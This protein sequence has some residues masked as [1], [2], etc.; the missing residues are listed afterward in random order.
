MLIARMIAKGAAALALAFLLVVG[1]AQAKDMTAAWAGVYG[2]EDG[3]TA[4]PF[5]LTLSQ[6]GTVITG[7]IQEVQTF[8]SKSSDDKLRASIIGSVSGHVVKFT[9]TYDGTGGQSH[10]VNYNGT[11]VVDGENMFMFGTW[12]IGADVGSWFAVVLEE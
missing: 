5:E 7:H 10:S 8:G 11:L 4:V 3:R 1:P 6:N 2:Y 9:K 12:R